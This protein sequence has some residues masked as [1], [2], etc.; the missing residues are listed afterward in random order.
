M[1]CIYSLNIMNTYIF[2]YREMPYTLSY[3]TRSHFGADTV[4]ISFFIHTCVGVVSGPSVD[5]IS[6]LFF[7]VNGTYFPFLNCE[8]GHVSDVSKYTVNTLL[9]YMHFAHGKDR[10][11]LTVWLRFLAHAPVARKKVF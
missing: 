9:E 1:G 10:P 8:A 2:L 5:H 11:R 6:N 4:G 3:I 7:S